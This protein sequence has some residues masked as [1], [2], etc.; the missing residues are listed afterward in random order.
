MQE[1]GIET[2]VGKH[3][4]LITEEL[5]KPIRSYKLGA[6][7]SKDSIV[8]RIQT[9]KLAFEDFD[10]DIHTVYDKPPEDIIKPVMSEIKR[11]KDMTAMIT[12]II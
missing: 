12:L 2:R 10:K 1:E 3:I 6:S 7:Y 9:R 4:S 5:N 8:E 11:Y